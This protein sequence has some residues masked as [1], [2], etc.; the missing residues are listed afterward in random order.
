LN[1]Y[2][3]ASLTSS[4]ID[5]ILGSKRLIEASLIKTKEAREGIITQIESNQQKRLI[6]SWICF[7]QEILF[8]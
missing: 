6:H 2:A 8:P 1:I 5:Q 7:N 3:K 4:K